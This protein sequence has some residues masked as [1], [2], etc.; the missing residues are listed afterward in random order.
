MTFEIGLLLFIIASAILLF[1]IEIIQADVVA[2][3]V[4]LSLILTGLL[5]PE[6]AF[7]GFGSETVLMLLGLFILTA[8]LLNT[9]VMDRAGRIIF[10]YT[11]DNPNR[12]LAIVMG[13]ATSLSAFISNTASAAFFVPIVIGLAEKT[14]I[15]ASKL[16]LPMAF[17]S[18]FA[19]SITLISTTTNVV[20][21]GL[22][23]QSGL[24]PLGMFELAP[25]GVPIVVVGMIYMLTLGRILMPN[26]D[27]DAGASI[28]DIG[29]RLYFTE[30]VILP[31]SPL[32]GT[33]LENSKLNEDFDVKVL[34]IVRHGHT[35]IIPHAGRILEADDILLIEGQRDDILQMK[36]SDGIEIKDDIKLSDP[37][38]QN[39]NVQ[40]VEVIL[41]PG[42]PL[43]GRSLR[44]YRFRE[45][46]GL[47][48]LAIYR[49]GETMRRELNQTRLKVGDILLVQS[50]RAKS[51]NLTALVESN[52]FQFLGSVDS[53]P[54]ALERAP[55]A[56][57][58]FIGVLV[59]ATFNLLSLPV[60]VLLGALIVFLT[61]CTTPEKA[62][63]EVHWRALILIGC[64][65]AVGQA[66]EET[67]TAEYLASQIVGLLG[68]MHP[69]WLLS[70]F[71]ALAVLLTQPMSNQAAAIVVVPIAI[72]TALQIDLNPRTF[73][74]MI[75]VAAST[76]YLT[77]LEPAC[78][79][80]Y[81]PGNYRFVDF[82]KVG[83][84]LTLL[85]FLVA[86]FLV[87]FFW[88]LT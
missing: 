39:E 46:Y 27:E 18:I 48:V 1:S 16:L 26:R 77:P 87:P 65:L 5:T 23:T 64:M 69:A 44:Q 24:P 85:I 70:G 8:A 75:A 74:V 4:L 22:M 80:V 45:R 31:E 73:A 76:S 62:Y 49:S 81:G 42:S 84:P 12:L 21:S 11:G 67:G 59:A 53:E 35:Y 54:L 32:V 20:I 72:Q 88:P 63:R 29:G 57:I 47:Q 61:R 28:G 55:I 78:L 3:G 2:L 25:I 52:T 14:R 82:L 50:P 36:E 83:T 13:A 30:M 9:G 34:R 79:M 51:S 86:I 17:A 40:L 56:I 60:A 66:M 19:S 71:F 68:D 43:I 15:S 41:L 38:L 10:H 6:L 37:Q 7:M 33:T 58:T